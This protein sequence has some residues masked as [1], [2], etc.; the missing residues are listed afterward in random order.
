ME[1]TAPGWPFR[2]IV[3]EI[4]EA[5]IFAVRQGGIGLWNL[6]AETM[7]GFGTGRASGSTATQTNITTLPVPDQVLGGAIHVRVSFG[8]AGAVRLIS[9]LRNTAGDPRGAR[10]LTASRPAQAR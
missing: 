8:A 3:K 6:G 2:R 5:V 7:F 9:P 1:A 4:P 10:T